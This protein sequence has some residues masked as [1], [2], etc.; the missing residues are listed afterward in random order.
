MLRPSSTNCHDIARAFE[1]QRA[2]S[3]LPGTAR[4]YRL[5]AAFSWLHIRAL[6]YVDAIE[7]KPVV[8]F[9]SQQLLNRFRSLP[10]AGLVLLLY[11]HH[12]A[13][14]IHHGMIAARRDTDAAAI[15]FDCTPKRTGW[16]RVFQVLI[17]PSFRWLPFM[18]YSTR[19]QD[20]ISPSN[21]Y[22]H[23]HPRSFSCFVRWRMINVKF[24]RCDK[25]VRML[26]QMRFVIRAHEAPERIGLSVRCPCCQEQCGDTG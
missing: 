17:L 10:T 15:A 13:T 5:G 19:G 16:W 18:A 6:A 7:P 24:D 21:F 23:L 14:E 20:H 26:R 2:L 25:L 1:V 12:D 8:V 4:R 3:L 9:I 22:F 11:V